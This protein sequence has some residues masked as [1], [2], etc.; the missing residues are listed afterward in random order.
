VVLGAA[1]LALAYAF[2]D[3]TARA[4]TEHLAIRA[5]LA[6]SSAGAP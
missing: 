3:A 2:L 6:H 1:F 5:A 4:W